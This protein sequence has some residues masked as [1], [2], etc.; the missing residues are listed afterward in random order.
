MYI[1]T[2]YFYFFAY[3]SLLVN[4]ELFSYECIE[5]TRLFPVLTYFCVN[6]LKKNKDVCFLWK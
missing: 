3:F 1:C 2:F 4:H 5:D 6:M